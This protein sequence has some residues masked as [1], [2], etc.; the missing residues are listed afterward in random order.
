MQSCQ[1]LKPLS[2]LYKNQQESRVV[3]LKNNPFGFL[4]TSFSVASILKQN[5]NP[6]RGLAKNRIRVFENPKTSDSS[7]FRG[8]RPIR[9]LLIRMHNVLKNGKGKNPGHSEKRRYNII[10]L[11]GF[12][13]P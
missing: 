9:V 6:A 8:F 7:S 3:L 2:S 10:P 1:K 5:H 4:V 11:Y 12:K 13:D